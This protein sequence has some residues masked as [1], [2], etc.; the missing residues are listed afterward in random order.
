[1]IWFPYVTSCCWTERREFLSIPKVVFPAQSY[2][3]LLPPFH[4]SCFLFSVLNIFTQN[5]LMTGM[6]QLTN[7]PSESNSIFIHKLLRLWLSCN[8]NWKQ[9]VTVARVLSL[10][11]FP[12]LLHPC[13]CKVN[14]WLI[15][16]DQALT[17]GQT[18]Q[19]CGVDST[20]W[21]WSYSTINLTIKGE[22]GGQLHFLQLCKLFVILDHNSND[23]SWQGV[24][25]W[26]TFFKHLNC[27]F[28]NI[29]INFKACL[30]PL[31][32]LQ[33][34]CFFQDANHKQSVQV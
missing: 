1:M 9:K 24:C 25:R 2:L 7:L 6:S 27:R 31:Q 3:G 26:N 32:K 12:F 21:Y 33:Q 30:L 14:N 23:K 13:N 18:E 28:Q 11:A 15:L 20:A 8:N 4:F 19:Y 17:F 5:P 29:S 34:Q 10:E 16:C 22:G